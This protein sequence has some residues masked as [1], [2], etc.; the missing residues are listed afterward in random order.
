MDFLWTSFLN[1]DYHDWRGTGASEDLLL[2]PGWMEK[3]LTR[4]GMPVPSEPPDVKSLR[5]LRVLIHRM[6]KALVAGGAVDPD[7]LAA[8]N[9]VMAGGPVVRQV[10]PDSGKVLLQPVACSW[11]HVQA[12]IA[13]SLATTLA[14]GEGARVRICENPDCLWFFYDDT[15]N[16]TK[17]FCE[18]KTCGNLVKVRRFRARQKQAGETTP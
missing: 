3:F 16:R 7:D 2:K 8:L 13:A 1:S 14:E 6:A 4:W 10:C 18:D 12:E 9:Q 5:Q 11:A 15:R 17:R